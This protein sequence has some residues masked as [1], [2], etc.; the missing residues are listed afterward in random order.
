MP[1]LL[2]RY[3]ILDQLG[4]GS[5]GIVYRALDTTLDRE[6]ALKVIRTGPEVDPEMRER[7]RREA[8]ACARLHHPGIVHIYDLGEI[9]QQAYF[10]MELLRGMDFR[11][12]IQRRA[13]LALQHKIE[14]MVQVCD[15]L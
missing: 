13:D 14:L 8:R 3:K 9:D 10:A 6:V 11:Q 15:A 2:G 5:M 4:A 1:L 7:F 12:L